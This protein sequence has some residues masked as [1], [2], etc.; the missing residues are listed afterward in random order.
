VLQFQHGYSSNL[1][2]VLAGAG[3]ILLAL[4]MAAMGLEVNLRVF[5][6]V[7]GSALAV[8]AAASVCACLV[9]W[10]LIRIML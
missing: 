6:K 3:E 7:G 5:A 10:A 8:G 2:D 1:A 9:S 4:S